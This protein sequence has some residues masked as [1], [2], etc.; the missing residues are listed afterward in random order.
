MKLPSG[1][2]ISKEMLVV[3]C[4]RIVGDKFMSECS[5][6]EAF[7]NTEDA[8]REGHF[9]DIP[10][11]SDRDIAFLYDALSDVVMDCE[12]TLRKTLVTFMEGHIPLV[13]QPKPVKPKCLKCGE[14]IE[15]LMGI[16]SATVSGWASIL[17][18]ELNLQLE[19]SL[20]LQDIIVEDSATWHCPRCDEQLFKAGE[21]DKMTVFLKGEISNGH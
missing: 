15:M 9:T 1:Y 11:L 3:L 17:K 8:L 2:E 13:G 4:E 10:A 5:Y 7:E 20:K 21:E 14:E 6:A 16:Y 12:S 19:E 18:G